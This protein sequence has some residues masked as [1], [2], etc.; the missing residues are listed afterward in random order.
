MREFVNFNIGGE[1]SK[2]ILE[3]L[4]EVFGVDVNS[5]NMSNNYLDDSTIP[6]FS[7]RALQGNDGTSGAFFSIQ[8]ENIDDNISLATNF[9]IGNG[10]SFTRYLLIK[11]DE[12]ESSPAEFMVYNPELTLNGPL[13]CFLDYNNNILI[14]ARDVYNEVDDRFLYSI[15]GMRIHEMTYVYGEAG[16]IPEAVVAGLT[17]L[18]LMPSEVGW[19]GKIERDG[20]TSSVE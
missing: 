6:L 19:R 14:K 15:D 17:D 8:G 12:N 18:G 16:I 4:C 1:F 9:M 2:E 20:N 10:I 7:Y 3:E 11:Y 13:T 5:L